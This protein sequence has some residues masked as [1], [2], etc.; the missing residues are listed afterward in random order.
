MNPDLQPVHCSR[1]LIVT[2]LALIQL[3]TCYKYLLI[4]SHGRLRI[5]RLEFDNMRYVVQ[6]ESL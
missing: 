1:D 3:H 2:G 4:F 5:Y 6:Y